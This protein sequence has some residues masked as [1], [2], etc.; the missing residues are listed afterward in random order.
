MPISGLVRREVLACA[1]AAAVAGA[2]VAV[3]PARPTARVAGGGSTAAQAAPGWPLAEAHVREAW[4]RTSGSSGVAIA[5]LDTGVAADRDDLRGAVRPG[6]NV[7][8]GNDDTRDDNGHGTLVAG[9]VAA[10]PDDAAGATGVC[11]RCTVVPVK[12]IAASGRGGAPAIAAGIRWAVDA[13]VRVVNMSF[14]MP[15]PDQSIADAVAYAR[16]HDVLLVA[17]AG[18]DGET[19]PTYPAAYPGVI[20]VAAVDSSTRLY[21]WSARGAWVAV[22]APGCGL[23][24]AADGGFSEFCGTSAAS[25]FV[26]G[27]AGLLFSGNPHATSAEV[28][29]ALTSTGRAASPAGAPAAV[30]AAAALGVVDPVPRRAV[31]TARSRRTTRCALGAAAKKRVAARQQR[32]RAHQCGGHVGKR[33]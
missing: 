26:A 20:G 33:G 16:A 11:P 27:V 17:G 18:N 24:T 31:L 4:R 23:S 1:C 25:A 8:A 29:R 15:D 30:D 19:S 13:G 9:I 3:L 22:A 10:R 32:T 12:V 6:F 2:A 7:I 14:S 21:P 5:L 28:A